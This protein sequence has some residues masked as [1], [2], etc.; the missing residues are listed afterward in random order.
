[1][2]GIDEGRGVWNVCSHSAIKRASRALGQFYDDVLAPCDLRITQYTVLSQISL[3]PGISPKQLAQGL[4][5]DLSALGHTLK[6]LT[7]D[8]FIRA[9]PDPADRRAKQLHLTEKGKAKRAEAAALWRNAQRR[10]DDFLGKDEAAAIRQVMSR[11]SSNQFA[12]TH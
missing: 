7:R 12:E 4:V 11:I 8:G 3:C 10:V 6:P 9:T 2:V 5:M 1:M